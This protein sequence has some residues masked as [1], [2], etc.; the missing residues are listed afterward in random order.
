MEFDEI[1][2]TLHLA[3]KGTP[4]EERNDL[5]VIKASPIRQMKGETSHQ[6]NEAMD[7][8]RYKTWCRR[9][10]TSSVKRHGRKR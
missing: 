3:I 4:D 5:F 6:I 2:I 8:H 7:P 10:P 1:F 9:N